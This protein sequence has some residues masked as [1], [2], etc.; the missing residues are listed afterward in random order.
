VM[1]VVAGVICCVRAG[2]DRKVWK[3]L[4]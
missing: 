2:W 4:C 3:R 1:L